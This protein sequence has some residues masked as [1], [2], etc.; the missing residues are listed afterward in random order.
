MDL[1]GIQGAKGLGTD[2]VAGRASKGATEGGFGDL[3]ESLLNGLEGSQAQAD[4]AIEQLALGGDVDIHD[5]VLAT[6][7][8]AIAFQFAIQVRNRF[9]E[10]VQTVLNM[11][12]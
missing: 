1:N 8:E 10:G 6:E 5:V 12:V 11:Q 7:M 2:A 9:V 3:L 4:S